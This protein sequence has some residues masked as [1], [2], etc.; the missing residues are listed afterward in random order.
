MKK[1]KY[2]YAECRYTISSDNKFI[3]ATIYDIDKHLRFSDTLI[4]CE[5]AISFLENKTQE[6]SNSF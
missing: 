2:S 4:N 6:I 3:F 1:I 5:K